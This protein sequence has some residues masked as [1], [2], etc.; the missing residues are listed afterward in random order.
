MKIPRGVSGDELVALLRRYGYEP[1]RQT[2][3]I[4]A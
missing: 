3:A 2:E 1:T 4:F